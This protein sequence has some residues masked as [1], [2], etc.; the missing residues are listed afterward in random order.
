MF[1]FMLFSVLFVATLSRGAEVVYGFDNNVP[2]KY[3]KAVREIMQ[4]TPG[5]SCTEMRKAVKFNTPGILRFS[6]VNGAFNTTVSL[7]AANL[8]QNTT[9]DVIKNGRLMAWI[10]YGDNTTISLSGDQYWS[11][12]ALLQTLKYEIN[13]ATGN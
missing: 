2:L 1:K 5:L 12:G 8:S 4:S 10:Y 7:P 13:K 6:W 9:G 11:R 3:K